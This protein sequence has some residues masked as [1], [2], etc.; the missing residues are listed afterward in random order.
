[1]LEGSWGLHLCTFRPPL[2]QN[3]QLQFGNCTAPCCSCT[4]FCRS[5]VHLCLFLPLSLRKYLLH[6][7]HCIKLSG[8][9]TFGCCWS[10]Y[11]SPWLYISCQLVLERDSSY[12]FSSGTPAAFRSLQIRSLHLL[13]GPPGGLWQSFRECLLWDA[14]LRHLGQVPKPLKSALR[15]LGYHCLQIPTLLPCLL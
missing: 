7:R 10:Y 9:A 6:T 12:H 11:S 8:W 3:Q 2:L 4:S 5:A 13:R 1:M 14:I 15:H